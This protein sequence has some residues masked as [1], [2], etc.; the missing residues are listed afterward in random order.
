M[1]FL[2]RHLKS[3]FRLLFTAAFF[4]PFWKLQ[5]ELSDWPES[6]SCIIMATVCSRYLVSDFLRSTSTTFHLTSKCA[7]TDSITRATPNL[8]LHD[9]P[10][11]PYVCSP[12]LLRIDKNPNCMLSSGGRTTSN[13]R[14][15]PSTWRLSVINSTSQS[16]PISAADL[17]SRLSCAKHFD[18]NPTSATSI[19]CPELPCCPTAPPTTHLSH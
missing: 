19:T 10:G 5:T 16:H 14:I 12:T 1:Y 17:T 18:Q 13:L 2:F 4:W 11:P 3:L 15:S 8:H 6:S 9:T 7:V